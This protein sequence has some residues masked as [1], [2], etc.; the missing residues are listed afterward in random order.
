M[1]KLKKETKIGI[2]GLIISAGLCALFMFLS[3]DGAIT[4]LP[5]WGILLR[6]LSITMVSSA[7]GFL[8]W[9]AG[10]KSFWIVFISME[11]VIIFLLI[12]DFTV[13]ISLDLKS[14]ILSATVIG[15]I[16][17]VF[18]REFKTNKLSINKEGYSIKPEPENVD[19]D[20]QEIIKNAEEC[21]K[22]ICFLDKSI[23]LS[24]Q[25][26]RYQVIKTSKYYFF[27]YVGGILKDIDKEKL[28]TDFE[29]IDEVKCV[30]NKDFIIPYEN[31]IHTKAIIHS[32][33][34]DIEYTTIKFM[35]PDNKS[36]NFTF[37]YDTTE[38]GLIQF[39][40]EDISITNKSNNKTTKFKIE[41]IPLLNKLNQGI[42]ITGSIMSIVLTVFIFFNTFPLNIYLSTISVLF[43]F[44][45]LILYIVFNKVLTLKENGS[46]ITNGKIPLLTL[47]ILPILMLAIKNL[48]S[49]KFILL[50]DYTKLLII[51]AILFVVLLAII[52]LITKEYKKFKSIIVTIV[53]LLAMLC[54]S[55]VCTINS[56]Y[57]FSTPQDISCTVIDKPIW[58]NSKNEETYYIT[59]NCDDKQYKNE[60][61]KEVYDSYELNDIVIV[62]KYNGALGLEKLVV[63]YQISTF[64]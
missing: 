13:I 3:P 14:V 47:T 21:Q 32:L 25:T 5:W 44:V 11:I 60:V 63:N 26:K 51:S 62:K 20:L 33:C 58:I 6:F 24:S 7:I 53:F 12:L 15:A 64:H 34:D 36:K 18:Y 39:F 29:N 2:W 54:P 46:L 49:L 8:F 22:S 41:D 23:I 9:W 55:V 30:D 4:E 45:P 19:E 57:D 42:F 48:L 10:P 40:G 61:S 52:L 31:I 43:C 50:Y 38:Q 17:F 16:L 56:A 35:L 1:S 27:K 28:I 37:M 59:I